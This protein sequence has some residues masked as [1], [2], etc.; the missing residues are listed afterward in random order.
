MTNP[1]SL[2]KREAVGLWSWFL[3]PWDWDGNQTFRGKSLHHFSFLLSHPA[4][5]SLTRFLKICQQTTV[6]LPRPHIIRGIFETPTGGSV[7][8][9][10]V[11]HQASATKV[12]KAPQTLSS[13]QNSSKA[14]FFPPTPFLEVAG[15]ASSPDARFVQK[16]GATRRAQQGTGGVGS[17][18]LKCRDMGCYWSCQECFA[19]WHTGRRS[20]WPLCWSVARLLSPCRPERTKDSRWQRGWGIPNTCKGRQGSEL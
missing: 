13:L 16:P 20:T 15:K 1:S 12:N 7:L 14:V 4:A 19:W 10:W 9:T 8:G 11:E 17:S 6:L 3:Q 18:S 5:F 2:S